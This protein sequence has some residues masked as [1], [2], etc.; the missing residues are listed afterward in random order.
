MVVTNKTDGGHYL[1]HFCPMSGKAH[2]IAEELFVLLARTSSIKTLLAVYLQM[3][4]IS[5]L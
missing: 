1:D 5:M 2:D 3:V 4:V